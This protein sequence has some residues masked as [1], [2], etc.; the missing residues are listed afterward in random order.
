MP[1]FKK[2]M[3]VR[4]SGHLAGCLYKFWETSETKNVLADNGLIHY[5]I[6]C[7]LSSSTFFIFL[8]F[9]YLFSLYFLS[10]FIL[11]FLSFST[12]FHDFSHFYLF[13][14][15]LQCL[16]IFL[17]FDCPS[18]PFSTTHQTLCKFFSSSLSPSLFWLIPFPYIS[19]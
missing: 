19:A 18:S 16:S 15:L 1:Y 3:Y 6:F 10:S 7:F 12:V 5:S 9:A 11:L 17:S 13:F 14:I 2:Q 4:L 8:I